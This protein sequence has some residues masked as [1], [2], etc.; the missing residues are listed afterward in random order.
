M[1]ITGNTIKDR[2]I[3]GNKNCRRC[4]PRVS[5][6]DIYPHQR[7]AQGKDYHDDEGRDQFDHSAS[8][9]N[10]QCLNSRKDEKWPVHVDRKAHHSRGVEHQ[11]IGQNPSTK[12]HSV[13]SLTLTWLLK[14]QCL[15]IMI[16]RHFV[17][18]VVRPI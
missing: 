15:I 11:D 7:A 2:Q 1:S 16:P 18:Y 13:V 4:H 12:K 3:D 6:Q 9:D 17:A 5:W 10:V 8:D 14:L